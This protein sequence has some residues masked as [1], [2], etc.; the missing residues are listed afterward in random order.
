MLKKLASSNFFKAGIFTSIYTFTKLVVNFLAGKIIALKF[1]LGGIALFGQFQSVMLLVQNLSNAAI[2]NGIIT[3]LSAEKEHPEAT[4]RIIA[5]AWKIGIIASSIVAVLLFVFK[6]TINEHFFQSQI[7][8]WLIVI[9]GFCS[10]FISFNIFVQSVLNAYAEFKLIS[11][12]NSV[13]SILSLLLLIAG[14]YWFGFDGALAAFVL[15]Y[16]PSAIFGYKI[17]KKNYPYS[18]QL[19]L[20]FAD[21]ETNKKLLSYSLMTV[22]TVLIFSLTQIGIRDLLLNKVG[23]DGAGFWEALN[24][25]SNF[26]ILFISMLFNSYYLPA[27]SAIAKFED[28]KS[29][30]FNTFKQL[31]PL[32]VV[33][34]IGLFILKSFII[35][36]VL[37]DEFLPAAEFMIWQNLGDL[38]KIS[39]WIF[40]NYL[41]AHKKTSLFIGFDL[42]YNLLYLGLTYY[43]I[44]ELGTLSAFKAYVYSSFV[45]LAFLLILFYQ[46]FKKAA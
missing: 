6:N 31:I 40:T 10:F 8:S 7:S 12:F 15:F 24:R 5:S 33:A 38:L 36:L 2:H 35:R 16:I 11:I 32:S 46:K 41:V 20:L 28:G 30:I 19:N 4:R 9:V 26:Y 25:I 17:L 45:G 1:S 13:Q 18:L 3:R 34:F 43:F 21:A 39:I 44:S 14:S 23:D 29:L 42:L 22:S 27:F 37:S